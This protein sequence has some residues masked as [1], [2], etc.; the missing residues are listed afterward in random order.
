MHDRQNLGR[1]P[2]CVDGGECMCFLE[3][4]LVD[5]D[6]EGSLVAGFAGCFAVALGEHARVEGALY[7]V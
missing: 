4:G 2:E 6:P 5:L 7:G 1:I 3:W